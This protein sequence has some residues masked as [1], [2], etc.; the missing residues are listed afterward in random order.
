MMDSR[1]PGRALRGAAMLCFLAA[2]GCATAPPPAAAPPGQIPVPGTA[3]A[4]RSPELPPIPEVD[5]PLAL[6]I[7][8]P[9]EGATVA[10]RDSNFIFGSTGSGRTQLTINGAAVDV[11]PNGGFLAFIPVPP[12]GVYRLRATKDGETA[13]LDHSIS[14][15]PLPSPASATARIVAPYPGGAR[16]VRAD[17]SV[18][19]GFD[20]P[21]GGRAALLLPDGRRIPLVERGARMEAVAG[22]QFRADG[23]AQ[24]RPGA[25]VRYSALIPARTALISSDTAVA[26]P[27]VG[28]LTTAQ[29]AAADTAAG[30]VVAGV[31]AGTPAAAD[32]AIARQA[33]FE[34]VA[35]GDTVRVPLRLN[36][37]VLPDGGARVAV[38]TAPADAA[39]DWTVRGRNDT[40]GPFHYFWPA[41]TLFTVTGERDGFYRVVLAGNRTAWVPAG[42]VTL[43]ADGT[44]PVAGA[45]NSVR[46]AP[47]PGWIDVRIPTPARM[48]FQVVAEENA[49]HID[50]FGATSR[51]NFFQYG[52]LDPLIR[53][54]EWEQVE[55]G[56]FRVSAFLAEPVWGYHTF[57]DDAGVLILRIRRPPRIDPAAPL[58]GLLI[59]VDPG[60]GGADRYTRGPTGLTEADANLY[61]SLR[62]RDM[63]EAAGARVMMTRERDMTVPLGDRPRMAADSNAHVLVSVH[64]NAFPDGVNPWTNA[65]TSM[66]YFHPHSADLARVMQHEMLE[67]LG[68][69]DIGFGRA[70]LALVRP[71]WMPAVLSETAF[72]MVPEQEAAL[73]DAGVQERIARA[74]LRALESFLTSRARHQH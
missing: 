70:D 43:L 27:R 1:L 25:L 74:H 18:E 41:G 13:T 54:A 23:A 52:A 46:F 48:P 9:P 45:I 73:R 67:E 32:A 7:G 62:L 22:Q 15:P 3:E 5:G 8:Y 4:R 34:L 56:V 66:Y 6:E 31:P 68:L 65:G 11:A 72:M 33:L 10:V 37:A 64:N 21:P 63:L 53:R 71:T 49:L 61:I 29:A 58:Q 44:P 30:R 35:G 16:A 39:H 28:S 12:D 38:A 60:H 19:V 50:V 57:Y 17:E 55:D 24:A 36:L 20:G 69:R 26:R 47:Q 42:D 40:S 14:L 59:A 2:S 51:A